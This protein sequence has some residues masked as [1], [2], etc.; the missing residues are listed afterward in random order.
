MNRH[1]HVANPC[2]T[3]VGLRHW[4]SMEPHFAF[5]PHQALADS[6]CTPRNPLLRPPSANTRPQGCANPTPLCNPC[7]SSLCSK[8]QS[9]VLPGSLPAALNHPHPHPSHTKPPRHAPAP[10]HDADRY[11]IGRA[12]SDPGGASDARRRQRFAFHTEY[13]LKKTHQWKR[14][15]P[16]LQAEDPKLVL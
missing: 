2:H 14:L 13:G 16:K 5:P 15:L 7:S 9:L 10:Q 11:P 1:L 12:H 6:P 4:P 3:R 8:M